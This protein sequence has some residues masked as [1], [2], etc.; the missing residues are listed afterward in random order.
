MKIRA[1][2]IVSLVLFTVTSGNY[3]TCK[4]HKHTHTYTFSKEFKDYTLFKTNSWW[5]YQLE[6]STLTDSVYVI[7]SDVDTAA[8]SNLDYKYERYVMQARSVFLNAMVIQTGQAATPDVYDTDH[9]RTAYSNSGGSEIVTFLSNK[10]P[11]FKFPFY[12]SHETMYKEL[13]P[14]IVLNNRTYNNVKVFEVVAGTPSDQRLPRVV[15]F[16]PNTGIIKK[17]LFNGQVWNLV[18]QQV[19]Q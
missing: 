8:D 3:C 5:V 16:S 12:S 2:I 7:E 4:K 11:G 14:S 13:L 6:N 18:R 19:I 17:E 15:Y 1:E 10:P 9:Q